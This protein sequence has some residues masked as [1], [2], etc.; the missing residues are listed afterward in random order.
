MKPVR[1]GIVCDLREE[2]WHSMDLV[3]DMLL[4]MLPSVSGGDN[5]DATVSSDD[6]PP[7]MEAAPSSA[8]AA[9]H[10]SATG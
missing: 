7:A 10:G 8:V 4:E 9:A 5:H 1:V 2:G 3:A 6:S